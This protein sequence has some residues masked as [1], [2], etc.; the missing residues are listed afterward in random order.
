MTVV[1]TMTA[2]AA[3]PDIY[4]LSLDRNL[5]TPEVPSKCV[6]RV[7]DYQYNV[8]MD[9][10]KRGY[11]VET[12]RDGLVFVITIPAASLFAP[13]DTVLS[14]AGQSLLKPMLDLLQP[15]GYCKLMLAM[16]AD[17]TGSPQYAE[18]LTRT[19]VN[20]VF[21][22]IDDNASVDY[23]VPY[24]EGAEDPLDDND[25]MEK[26]KHN[27]RLEIYVVPEAAMIAKA[28]KGKVKK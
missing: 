20:A 2:R 27:R 24:A 22:W 23:V 21:D 1:A 28:K 15:V 18:W 12:M 7:R 6:D 10:V 11:Q 25:S 3:E 26:R 13:C 4:E 5:T 8:A 16:H 14:R 19:R 9:F 17:D